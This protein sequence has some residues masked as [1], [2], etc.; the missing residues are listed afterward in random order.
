MATY[1]TPGVYVEEI[2]TLPPSVAEVETAIPA[3]I[4]F[5]ATGAINVPKRITSIIEYQEYFGGAE[6]E[7]SI[8]VTLE[9]NA[10]GN[11]DA[12]VVDVSIDPAA[13]SRHVMYYAMQLFFANGGGPCYIIPAGNFADSANN[14]RLAYGAALGASSREDEPTLLVFPDASMLLTPEDYYALMN[15]AL[16]ECA[17]LGDRF[18]IIDVVNVSGDPQASVA[19]FRQAISANLAEIKYGAAYHPYLNT[20]I[21]YNYNPEDVTV[22]VAGDEVSA[23]NVGDTQD[24]AQA[25]RRTAD[26]ARA[27]AES[28][29]PAAEADGADAAAKRAFRD[30]N[31]QAD[32]LDAEARGAQERAD[33]AGKA[34]ARQTWANQ[35]N[36]I[37][38]QIKRMIGTLGVQLSPCAAVAG[39]YAG[40]DSTRGVWK[41]PANVSLNYVTSTS[42]K[43]TDDDQKDLNIDVVAGK[44]VNAI[45]AFVGMGTKIWG[46]RTL[47]G[48]DNEWRYINVRRFFNMVEES[49]KKST[50][51]VVFEPNDINTWIRVRAMIENYLFLKWKDGALAGVKPEDA[52]FVRVGIGQTMTPQDILEGRMIIE[53]GLAAVRPAE[54]IILRFS[55]FMQK[56]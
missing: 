16:A 4:G 1:K 50:F 19:G 27:H 42:T 35:N 43:I 53:I 2:T 5:T 40:V 48:N 18:A 44:S 38:N 15:D 34:V 3:F 37:Q 7:R 21:D 28:L 25:A 24:A 17:R 49:I 13:K 55:H 14:P 56:S 8:T 47:A 22:L 29:R 9:S 12:R 54:F 51:W 20:I 31:T 36:A 33:A 52:Y 32:K 23:R 26:A 6:P 41:A 39:V 45:R 10:G 30:A 11:T 46:A